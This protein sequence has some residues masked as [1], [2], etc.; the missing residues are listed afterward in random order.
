MS[1]ALI[2]CVAGMSSS[3][4][5]S[6]TTEYLQAQ[7]KDI[8][9]EAISSNEGEQVIADATYD[10]YLVSPQAGMY[11]NQFAAVGAE[12]GRPVVKVPPQ[13]Y[14]PIPMGIE[15]MAQLILDNLA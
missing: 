1:K 11:Y 7:G 9:V 12:A 15:K 8:T 14:V 2:I 4:M 13:A 10:V 6:K 5:A 3:L